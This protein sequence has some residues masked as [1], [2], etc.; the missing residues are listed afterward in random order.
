MAALALMARSN[1]SAPSREAATEWGGSGEVGAVDW[2]EWIETLPSREAV[3]RREGLR[4]HH[5]TSKDQLLE[6]VTCE[7]LWLVRARKGGG[8]AYLGDDLSRRRVP[9]ERTAVLA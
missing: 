3:E 4:G 8:P 7:P 5:W 6:G 1:A 9:A 2:I